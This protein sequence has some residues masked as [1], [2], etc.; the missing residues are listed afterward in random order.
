MSIQDRARDLMM[1]HTLQVRNRQQSL[2]GR[3]AVEVGLSLEDIAHY[4]GT[5]QGKLSSSVRASY[6]RSHASLS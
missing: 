3:T 2:L 6:D 1:R 4:N 5:I